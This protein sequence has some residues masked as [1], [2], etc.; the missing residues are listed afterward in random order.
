MMAYST[1]TLSRTLSF[2]L[3]VKKTFKAVKHLAKLRTNIWLSHAPHSF[4]AFLL[5]DAELARLLVYNGQKLSI[6]VA[7]LISRL[8]WLHYHQ[9]SDGCREFLTHRLTDWR[10]QWLTNCWSCATFCSSIFLFVACS[11]FVRSVVEFLIILLW[12]SYC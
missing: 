12:T 10:Y 3:L 1:T 8:I 5:K 4:C 7:I 2:R 9:I 11:S 6:N